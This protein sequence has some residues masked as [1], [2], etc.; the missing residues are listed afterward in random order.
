MSPNLAAGCDT[1]NP[2]GTEDPALGAGMAR[3]ILQQRT[4]AKDEEGTVEG[5][6][7]Q[8]AQIW[9]LKDGSKFENF[10]AAIHTLRE[11]C[12]YL[13]QGMHLLEKAI[14]GKADGDSLEVRLKFG[15]SKM[16]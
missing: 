9:P 3:A 13:H 12:S 7:T 6:Y 2:Q 4:E 5:R 11:A 16:S 10:E 1:A 14:G 15:R 8:V